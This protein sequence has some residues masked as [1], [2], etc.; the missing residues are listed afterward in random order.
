MRAALPILAVVALAAAAVALRPSGG[1]RAGEPAVVLV[2]DLAFAS[3]DG[4]DL[5]LDLAHPRKRAGRLPAV[6]VI[7]GGGWVAGSRKAHRDLLQVLAARGYVAAGL[8]YRFAPRHRWPAQIH[9]VQAGVRWLRSRAAL[10]GLNPERIGA[11]GFS[12]GA[13]LAMLLGTVDADEGL[14]AEAASAK[15][16]AVVS[17]FGPTDLSSPDYP[18]AAR[19]LIEGLL[20]PASAAGG[21]GASPVAYVSRGDAPLLLLHG[22]LDAVVPVSQATRMGEALT[23]AG[24]PGEVRLLVGAHHGWDGALL[25]DT[26]EDSIRWFDRHLKGE[27]PVLP[28]PR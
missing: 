11:I 26:V 2:E 27:L 6:V 16:Q 24:V 4:H 9:D 17:W 12:A 7:H 5:E 28:R 18:E 10:Y 19:R 3:P 22:T 1:A 8:S 20:G 25:A 21:G 13:H 23:R 14:G 15:V